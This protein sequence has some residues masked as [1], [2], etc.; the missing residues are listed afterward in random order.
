MD[1]GLLADCLPTALFFY[2]DS[3]QNQRF[4]KEER[5]S[6]WRIDESLPI[7]FFC[8]SYECRNIIKTLKLHSTLNIVHKMKCFVA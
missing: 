4:G 7:R 5:E 8:V 6:D 3:R 2:L 1:A